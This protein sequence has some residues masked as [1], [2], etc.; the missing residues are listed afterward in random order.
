[1]PEELL[2]DDKYFEK[3]TLK[4]P[5]ISPGKPNKFAG[6]NYATLDDYK[7]QFDL[8]TIRNVIVKQNIP[9]NDDSSIY[10]IFNRLNTG[11]VNLRPQEIRASLYHS[12]FYKMLYRIN[13]SEGWRRLLG[14]PEPDLNMRDVE[15]LLRGFSMFLYGK[16]YSSSM[17]GFLNRSSKLAKSFSSD[18]IEQLEKFFEI[19]LQSC[20][21]LPGDI[22][23]SKSGK[24]S[25]T[26]FE[27]VFSAVCKKV[28][29]DDPNKQFRVN[30]S[31]LSELR[32]DND[33]INS[34][35]SQS[36]KK[37]NVTTRLERAEKLVEIETFD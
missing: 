3:F 28:S 20:S 29:Q 13:L 27:S 19:F 10:E 30:P 26:M 17:A 15:I 16:T 11:G 8:R 18:Q 33:F 32:A 21:H 25:V 9:K 4:L 6:R 22:F 31:S 35:Q 5:E 37:G 23:F 7:I 24:F 12:D 2:H 36:N 1:M 14:V 34:S